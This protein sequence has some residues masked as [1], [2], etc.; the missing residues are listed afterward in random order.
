MGKKKNHKVW[1]LPGEMFEFYMFASWFLRGCFRVLLF[2]VLVWFYFFFLV[3]VVRSKRGAVRC[4][5]DE[6]R[7][8]GRV[9]GRFVRVAGNVC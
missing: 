4:C 3:A 8:A 1:V 5:W 6:E 2:V 7:G 9:G